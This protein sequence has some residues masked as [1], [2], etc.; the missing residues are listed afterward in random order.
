MNIKEKLN[1]P[2]L[3]HYVSGLARQH[4]Y[5]HGHCRRVRSHNLRSTS[6]V[7]ILAKYGG[8][9]HVRWHKKRGIV[10]L[11][12]RHCQEDKVNGSIQFPMHGDAPTGG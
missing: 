7:D 5:D 6:I 8:S 12:C 10:N 4:L 1:G 11:N 9:R 2:Y 3:R